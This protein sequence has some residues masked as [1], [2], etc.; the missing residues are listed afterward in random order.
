MQI[1][2]AD[3]DASGV[4][5]GRGAGEFGFEWIV[6]GAQRANVAVKRESVD[7][8]HQ[9]SERSVAAAASAPAQEHQHLALPGFGQLCCLLQRLS[10][11]RG[12]NSEGQR[13]SGGRA[14]AVFAHSRVELEFQVQP[15]TDGASKRSNHLPAF[16][17][18][19]TAHRGF[20]WEVV[21]DGFE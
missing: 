1:F 12:D 5:H 3:I 4:P 2:W 11:A 8:F 14:K 6:F 18:E 16:E 21:T 13:N 10:Y 20:G 19:E 15:R 9:N 17:L 7:E